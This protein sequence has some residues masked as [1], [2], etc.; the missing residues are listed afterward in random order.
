MPCFRGAVVMSLREVQFVRPATAVCLIACIVWCAGCTR[1]TSKGEACLRIGDY[2][3]AIVFFDR[4]IKRDP[5]AARPRIG[6]AKAW[7]QQCGAPGGGHAGVEEWQRAVDLLAHADNLEPGVVSHAL[8]AQVHDKLARACAA[9]GDS[10]EA[11]RAAN[12]AVTL[13]P[14]SSDYL[15]FAALLNYRQGNVQH[16][17]DQLIQATV[18]DSTD[19]TAFYNLGM[20]AWRENNQLEAQRWWVQALKRAPRNPAVQ[21]WF[22]QAEVAL[23]EKSGNDN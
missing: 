20:L 12:R 10:A 5:E 7:I 8:H 17:R 19:Y 23:A 15:N 1:D 9:E 14:G 13:A 3:N 4:A 22:A 11:L 2:R 18:V 21:Y 16:A 6:M